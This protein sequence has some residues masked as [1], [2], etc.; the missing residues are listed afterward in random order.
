MIYATAFIYPHDHD[1]TQTHN[2]PIRSRTPYPLGHAV[3]AKTYD[4]VNTTGDSM[5]IHLIKVIK[6]F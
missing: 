5:I 3:T 2:L 1:G 6:T 4:Y